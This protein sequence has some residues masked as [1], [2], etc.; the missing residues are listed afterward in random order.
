[1]FAPREAERVAQRVDE[2][3][4][5]EMLQEEGPTVYSGFSEP[6]LHSSEGRQVIQAKV[7]RPNS[8]S[9]ERRLKG[10]IERRGQGGPGIVVPVR[11]WVEWYSVDAGGSVGHEVRGS[12]GCIRIVG[13]RSRVEWKMVPAEL[14]R[15]AEC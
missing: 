6:C 8:N 2:V 4:G 1:M 5:H 13:M 3:E 11:Y 14:E 7:A 15:G 12:L 9:S 10:T